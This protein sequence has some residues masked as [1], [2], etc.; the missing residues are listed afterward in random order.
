M[1]RILGV[2]P[3]LDGGLVILGEHGTVVDRAIMPTLVK[4]NGKRD[5][6]RR[7]LS[8]LVETWA[9]DLAYVEE[10]SARPKQGVV[11]S[12]AFGKGYGTVLM[13]MAAH[14]VGCL[15]VRPQ[16]WQ[17]VM[18]AGIEAPDT[19]AAA[20]QA[21]AAP[22]ALGIDWRGTARS[23]VPHDGLVDAAC[24]ARYGWLQAASRGA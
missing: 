20:L 9:P 16:V 18:F 12:F 1:T 13:A 7:K 17:R 3:G 11:S 5:I 21:V 24:I 6:D 15:E 14:G 23:K 19:K 8:W 2:D 22:W 10:V 4:E